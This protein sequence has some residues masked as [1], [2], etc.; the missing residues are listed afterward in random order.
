MKTS[1]KPLLI[2]SF[3]CYVII[4][5]QPKKEFVLSFGSCNNQNLKNELWEPILQHHPDLFIWG[6]DIIYA[7]TYDMSFMQKNYDQMKY[8]A[9]YL[10][11]KSRVPVLGTWDDHD[12]GLNDGGEHYKQKD[13]VQ[14]LFLDFFDVP[15]DSPRRSQKG[16][17]FSKE[18]KVNKSSIKVIVLDTRYFRSDLTKDPTGVK[19]YVPNTSSDIT[20]LGATQ[21]NWLEQELKESKAQFNVIMSSIQFL[22]YEHGFESWGTMP[23]EVDKMKQLIVDS[24]AKGV[25]ILSGDRHI[26][27]ISK[28]ELP[29]LNYPLIDF[30]SSGMTHSYESFDGETNPYRIADV[31]SKKNFGILRFDFDNNTVRM[32]IRGEGNTLYRSLE[33]KF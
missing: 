29:G 13:S 5:C 8:E 4:G 2:I 30:T 14:Q 20:M 11:F 7:D 10:D 9:D 28:T 31:V 25:I 23:K 27:E 6:G 17:Y 3:L 32:E 33:Q 21:W 22:S 16:I 12:Y 15:Q 18:Y 19:R 24:Q 26:A 1:L